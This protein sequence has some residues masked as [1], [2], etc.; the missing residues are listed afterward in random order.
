LYLLQN[1]IVG[2]CFRASNSNELSIIKHINN[3]TLALKYEMNLLIR[4]T[5]QW[6]I[7]WLTMYVSFLNR[8]C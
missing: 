3:M 5:F 2:D 6:H 7:T 8:A 1:G 4:I